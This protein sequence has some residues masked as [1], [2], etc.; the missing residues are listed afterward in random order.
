MYVFTLKDDLQFF[1][2]QLILKINLKRKKAVMTWEEK[3]RGGQ[4]MDF[5]KIKSLKRHKNLT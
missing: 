4:E 3:T 1:Y 2:Q 5:Q